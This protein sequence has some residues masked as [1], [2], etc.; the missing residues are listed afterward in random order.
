MEAIREQL[1]NPVIAGITGLVAGM[2]VGLV[3]LGWWLFPVEWTN[4][5][6]SHLRPDLQV[7]YLRMAIDSY[8][9]GQDADKAQERWDNLGEDANQTLA[10]VEIDP[11]FQSPE[12]IAAFRSLV[13][14][15][16]GEPGAPEA[17]GGAGGLLPVLCLVALLLGLAFGG[18]YLLR[19]RSTRE[20]GPVTAAEYAAHLSRDA[21]RTDY[22]ENPPVGQF[23]TTYMLGDD[24]FDDSFSI[25]SPSGEFL[26][27]C[28]AGISETIG[29]GDPKRV[30][31]FEVWLFDKNDIQTV[32]RVLMSEH[33][34]EDGDTRQ[35]LSTKGE[36]H[37]AKPGE[38][39]ELETETLQMRARVVDMTYG[40]GPLPPD[41]Y[42]DRITLEL[43]V[44][45]KEV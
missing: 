2:V 26:G 18:V 25:D 17:G 21:E 16:S 34:Y 29:V 32:T 8:A 33:S 15:E 27:E 9:Q 3:V 30:S 37:L 23:M 11:G 35:R 45:Q 28:G 5:D 43:A 4:A 20:S 39:I 12:A 42:F 38:V 19:Q 22:S 1:K 44:W 40:E 6:A 14:V 7:D 36:P 10:A 13:T 24:L 41:S 31:S